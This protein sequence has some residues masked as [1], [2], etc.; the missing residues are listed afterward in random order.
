MEIN[1]LL[2]YLNSLSA[3]SPS[4]GFTLSYLIYPQIGTHKQLLHIPP[5]RAVFAWFLLSGL[6]AASILGKNGKE[7]VLRIYQ[8]GMIFSDINSFLYNTVSKIKLTVIGE[9]DLQYIKK[10]DF[11]EK[12]LPFPETKELIQH[13]ILLEQ[14][15]DLQRGLLISLSEE[16]RFNE[17]ASSYPMNQIPNITGASFTNMTTSAYC[18]FK[19][20]WNGIN[21]DNASLGTKR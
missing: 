14:E 11:D 12:I 5:E 15:L 4:F 10:K 17:F 21:R 20:I 3:T 8:P 13:I 7:V 2:S 16:E 19:A 9:A 1:E 6:V 18:K